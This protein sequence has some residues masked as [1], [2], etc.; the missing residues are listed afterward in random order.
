MTTMRALFAAALAA[1][2]LFATGCGS[3]GSSSVAADSPGSGAAL[4][5]SDAGLWISVDTSGS[6]AQWTALNAVL[7]QIPGADNLVDDALARAS[8]R[9]GKLD[10]R[11]DV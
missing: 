5:P 9:N 6:S 8:S 2:A 3:S 7:A 10:F 4:A 1:A 11:R